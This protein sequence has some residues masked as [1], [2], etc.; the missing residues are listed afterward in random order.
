MQKK[1]IHFCSVVKRLLADRRGGVTIYATFVV[2]AS[3]GAGALVIDVGRMTIL[4][5]QLQDRA[6]AGALAAASQLDG[7]VTAQDRARLLATNAMAQSS[8]IPA[9]SAALGVQSVVF[10]SAMDPDEVLA[11]GDEDSFFVRVTM[12]PKQVNYFFS[13]FLPGNDST[14]TTMGAQ[15]VARANP[16]ICHAP[17]LMICDPK[18]TDATLDLTL[19]SNVGRQFQLKPPSGG[20]AWAPGNYGLLALPDGSLGA[21]SLEEALAAVEP[22]DCYTLDVTTATGVKTNKIQSGV[23]A[24]FDIPGGL[25]YPAP[26]VINFPKDDDV[27]ADPTLVMGSGNWD[28]ATY[29]NDRHGVAQP[30]DLDD[31][32]RYQAYLYELGLEYARNGKQTIYPLPDPLPAGYTAISPAGA[33]IP[34]DAADP[35]NP[36]VDGVP[37]TAVADNGQAR[38]LVKAAILQCISEGVRGS[39]SYPTNGN[40][41]ELFITESVAEE[42]AGGI[43]GEIVRPL[44]PSS[45]PD[46][47]A[48]VS[49]TE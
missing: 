7:R 38:R 36:D 21:S 41:I 10:Y 45:D 18:E 40:Y 44:S 47:H 16:F 32:S 31:A 12:T 8:G 17:P 1:F 5:S 35:D 46:F 22:Q 26:N 34:V 6:D 33:D 42:P 23:N 14:G 29:W 13:S 27:L 19:A 30:A 15:A 39:H 4:R 2:L 25:P 48:N 28:I 9:D 49:L 37:S 11:A 24:R 20:G 43:Y 3:L